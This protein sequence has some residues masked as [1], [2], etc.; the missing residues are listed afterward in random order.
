MEYVVVC[1]MD[2]EEA[3]T[4]GYVREAEVLATRR[5]F[6]HEM[7]AH[8][9]ASTIATDRKPRVALLTDYLINEEGWRFVP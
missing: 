3:F 8:R 2:Y 4:G 1:R 9:Y 5:I 7:D 6:M